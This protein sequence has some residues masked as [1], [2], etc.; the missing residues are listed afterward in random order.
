MYRHPNL[1]AGM[2]LDHCHLGFFTGISYV[3]SLGGGH[4]LERTI[5]LSLESVL[6]AVNSALVMLRLWGR[7]SVL[8]EF[9]FH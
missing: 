4:H 6:L 9:F 5:E 2:C 7:V 8:R 1:V 3:H